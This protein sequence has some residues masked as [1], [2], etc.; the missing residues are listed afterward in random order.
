MGNNALKEVFGADKVGLVVSKKGHLLYGVNHG[1]G[2][3]L[4]FMIKNKI[5]E[6]WNF[7]VCQTKG[8]DTF[9]PF[10]DKG[11]RVKGFPD[12]YY[13]KTC[14][15]CSKKW[16]KPRPTWCGCGDELVTD[17][18]RNTWRC[19]RCH[20]LND[21]PEEPIPIGK[22]PKCKAPIFTG[23]GFCGNCKPHLR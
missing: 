1:W 11:V 2:S 12:G 6:V 18:E 16:P 3:W 4:P 19:E 8:H 17:F 23:V 13:P 22:C 21:L 14:T 15:A 5:V 7:L 20:D 9:G 10:Y